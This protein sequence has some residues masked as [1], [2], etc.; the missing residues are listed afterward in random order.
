MKEWLAILENILKK[1]ALKVNQ[2]TFVIIAIVGVLLSEN[3]GPVYGL[4][5]GSIFSLVFLIYIIVVLKDRTGKSEFAIYVI[6][7]LMAIF[8]TILDYFKLK[9]ESTDVM[10]PFFPLLLIMLFVFGYKHVLKS[11]DEERIEKVKSSMLMG[12]PF[13]TIIFLIMIYFTFL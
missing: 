10:M 7:E 5:I 13:F 6:C 4:W 12:I 9:G 1:P 3:F 8:I 11:G 2:S